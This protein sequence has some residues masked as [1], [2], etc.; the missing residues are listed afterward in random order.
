MSDTPTKIKRVKFPYDTFEAGLKDNFAKL[1]GRTGA[2][3]CMAKGYKTIMWRK[4][5]D[6][7]QKEV[8]AAQ[9]A[10]REAANAKKS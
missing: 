1:G 5:A 4:R 2:L 8:E 10:A 9:D 3:R 6:K 7:N